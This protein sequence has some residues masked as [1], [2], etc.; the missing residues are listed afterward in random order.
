MFHS[1]IRR[2]HSPR[3]LSLA[4]V[5]LD[6]ANPDKS[7][8]RFEMAMCKRGEPVQLVREPKN[9]VDKHAIIV[10]SARGISL[11]YISFQRSGLVSGWLDAGET[12]EAQFQEPGRTAA[13]IRARFGGG[14]LVLPPEREDVIYDWS[15]AG[16]DAF[17]WGC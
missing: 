15:D 11:G 13:I 10:L 5:G 2:L 7:N 8:R 4:V 6:Y 17:N 3:E 16:G 1:P 12:Y 14:R 9:P